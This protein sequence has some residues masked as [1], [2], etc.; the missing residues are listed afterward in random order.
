MAGGG[1][2]QQN[3]GGFGGATALS[4]NM[5][6]GFGGMGV[7]PYLG[8]TT[9]PFHPVLPV[10]TTSA[11]ANGVYDID[12]VK[13]MMF[14]NRRDFNNFGRQQEFI[15]NPYQQMYT[16]GDLNK[17]GGPG[18]GNNMMP[19]NMAYTPVAYDVAS[20]RRNDTGNMY[21]ASPMGIPGLLG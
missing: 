3:T 11:Q 14:D 20:R 5:M 21:Q 19:N 10:N 9:N 6:P 1:I 7:N 13:P 4:Q 17:M 2:Q 8:Q 15:T 16:Q 18:R 12:P